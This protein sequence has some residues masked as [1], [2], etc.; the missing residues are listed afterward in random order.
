MAIVKLF[1]V[2]AGM[3]SL[4]CGLY[5]FFWWDAPDTLTFFQLDISIP[6]WLFCSTLNPLFALINLAVSLLSVYGGICLFFGRSSKA[7]ASL[8]RATGI[9]LLPV[10]VLN[11]FALK[12][13]DVNAR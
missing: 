7:S 4:V 1:P 9:I 12:K 6:C 11:F 10:G 2:L 8:I 5:C 13:R 3:L